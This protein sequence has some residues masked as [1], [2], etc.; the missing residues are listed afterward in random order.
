MSPILDCHIHSRFSPDGCETVEDIALAA[1]A[2]GLKHIAVTDHC[3]LKHP[4]GYIGVDDSVMSEYLS[5]LQRVKEKYRDKIYISVG[6]EAGYLKIAQSETAELLKNSPIEYIINS[7]HCVNGT[8]CYAKGHFDNLDKRAAYEQ[9]LSDVTDSLDAPYRYDAVGHLG[10][11][12]RVAPY[13]DRHMR[14]SEFQNSL[15][16]I[17]EKIIAQD[18]ILELNTSLSKATGISIPNVDLV[19]IFYDMGGR[20]VTLSSDAHKSGRIAD[21]FDEVQR[22]LKQIG[23]SCLTAKQNGEIVQFKL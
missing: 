12:E 16:K 8:D 14:F 20:L 6:L 19:K 2:R 3:D 4:E 11:I 21:G 17:F 9:Y 5:E 10:Y 18:T 15:A 23:F 13:D 7:V 22:Q 1:I